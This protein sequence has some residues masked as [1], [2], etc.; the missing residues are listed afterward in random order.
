M[1]TPFF[2][3]RSFSCLNIQ[4]PSFPLYLPH[5][6]APTTLPVYPAGPSFISASRR[7]L[8]KRSFSEDDSAVEAE[9]AS[10]PK[11]ASGDDDANMFPGLGEEREGQNLLSLD[12][13][14]WKVGLLYCLL[15]FQRERRGEAS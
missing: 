3:S 13:K 1:P 7:R 15:L 5:P 4:F 10:K 2:F 12:A 8:L 11:V 14:E 6:T 9:E